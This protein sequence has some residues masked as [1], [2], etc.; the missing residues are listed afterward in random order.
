MRIAILGIRGIPANY[1]GF[2]TFAAE[3]APRLVQRGHDVTVYG[4]SGAV[5]TTERVYKG[6]RLVVLPTIHT[7]HL[8]TPVHTMVSCAHAMFQHY[9]VVLVCNAANALF[10]IALRATRTPVVLNVDG[11]ERLRKKW[12]K[13]GRGWYWMSEFL[14]TKIPNAIVSDAGVIQ[15]YYRQRWGAESAMIPYGATT[16]CP[17]G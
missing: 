3:L 16:E 13:A 17:E 15:D 8:D 1:G 2:E 14:A 6:V 7:K 10:T 5:T 12:S 11:I 4:R 9:D